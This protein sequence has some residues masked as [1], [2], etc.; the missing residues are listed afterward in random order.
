MKISIIILN[1]NSWKDTSECLSSL[2]KIRSKH[3]VSV[4]VVDNGSQEKIHNAKLQIQRAL[5]DM[6]FS[7][8]QTFENLG[9]SGGNNVGIRKAFGSGAD[10][11]LLLNNDTLVHKNF[12]DPLVATSKELSDSALIGPKIY[13]ASG[14]E[15]H[16]D[17]YKSKDRGNVIWY[18]GGKIDW[19]NVIASHEGVD[20]VDKKQ[21]DKRKETDFISGCCMLFPKEVF[22]RVGTLD[23]KY[24]LYYEDTDLCVRAKKKGVKLVY[25][26]ASA[27]WHKN[28][29]SSGE[30]GSVLHLYYQTRNRLIFGMQYAS[31]RAK[32]ALFR[33][34]LRYLGGG[35]VRRLAVLHYFF[36]KWGKQNIS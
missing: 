29:Q 9:F 18:A 5:G 31:I 8:I 26:P 10:Y 4:I 2:S 1:Y 36:R 3:N 20:E 11:V 30:S 27:I 16:K 13:F 22:D 12:I 32:I 35:G 24:F 33:E 6:P 7:Y 25:E 28:A 19:K 15:F 23:E 34:A 14:F 21:F 17:R